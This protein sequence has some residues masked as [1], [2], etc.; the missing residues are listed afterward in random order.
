MNKNLLTLFL[1]LAAAATTARA[2][3]EPSARALALSVQEALGQAKTIRMTAQHTINPNRGFG[4]KLKQGPLAIT[5]KRPN[6]F[7][8]VQQAGADTR[9]ISFNGREFCMMHPQLKH[10]AL[11]PLAANSIEQFTDRMDEQFGFRPPVAELLAS[12][13]SSQL[14]MHVTSATV[15][16]R[17]FVGWTRCER[18][19]FEQPGMAGD[20]WVGVKDK[21]PRRYQLTFTDLPNQPRW[22]IRFTKWELNAPTDDSLFSKRPAPDS[23]KVEMFKSR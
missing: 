7:F 19:H 4:I 20:L 23:I 12:D 15:T 1:A 2:E 21:L 14:F 3:I 18:L 17:E 5:V 13:L 11:V 6:Q 10:H 9:E 22:D 8:A 16:G